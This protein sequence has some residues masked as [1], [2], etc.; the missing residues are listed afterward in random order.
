MKPKEESLSKKQQQDY[1]VQKEKEQDLEFE[2]ILQSME[3]RS[4]PK[5]CI[6]V[7]T[8]KRVEQERP[9]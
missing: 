8:P 5:E 9:V 6:K 3:Q 7:S 1:L 2:K 4:K